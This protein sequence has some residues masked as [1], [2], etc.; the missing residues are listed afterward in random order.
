M[1]TAV[2]FAAMPV[3][4]N[5][6]VPAGQLSTPVPLAVQAAL[7]IVAIAVLPETIVSGPPVPPITLNGTEPPAF[8]D[9]ALGLIA[10]EAEAGVT[11]TVTAAVAP[12]ASITVMVTFVLTAT[13]FGLIVNALPETTGGGTTAVLLEYTVYGAVPPVIVNAALSAVPELRPV[14]VMVD[15][16]TVIFA[17]T[18]PRMVSLAETVAPAESYTLS[19]TRPAGALAGTVTVI[20]DPDHWPSPG[21]LS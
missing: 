7:V 4:S 20:E 17:P 15:G 19:V 13:G 8:M 3:T 21:A 14:S 9:T 6:V 10:R 11:V 16:F 12:I 1:V 5:D 18:A 2:V